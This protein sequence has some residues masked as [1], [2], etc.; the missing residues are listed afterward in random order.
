M[1][2][3]TFVRRCRSLG[4]AR[5][6]SGQAMLIVLAA[7]ALM[8]TVPLVVITT[9]VNQLP[10][11]TGNLNWNAAY[12][13]AQA[14]LNDYLQ[15]VDANPSYTQWSG[16]N[17]GCS[18]NPQTTPNV[19][20]AFC[21]WASSPTSTSP[22]A[23]NP[24]EWYEYSVIT[25]NGKVVLTV[26][27]KAGTG[28]RA[29]VRTFTYQMTPQA[30]LDDIYWTNYEEPS[31]CT[32][33]SCAIYFGSSDVLNGPVYSNDYFNISGSPTFNATVASSSANAPYWRCDY[34]NAWLL[35]CQGQPATASPIFNDGAPTYSP[36][37]NI[38][39]N[40]TGPD[41]NPAQTLGCYIAGPNNTSTGI[42]IT[43]SG[44]Q[45]TWTTTPG[46]PNQ[47]ATV[48]NLLANKNT[49][50]GA[51]GAS[52]TFS[53]LGSALFYVNGDIVIGSSQGAQQV[54][55]F[56]DL[57]STG[58]ITID[59]S[60]QYPSADITWNGGTCVALTGEGCDTQD[61]L[62][63]IAE[64]NVI[65]NDNNAAT[66]IDAAMVAIQGSFYN[67]AAT[68][69]C[70]GYGGPS[71]NPNNCPVL[72][73]FGSIAQ[74]TRGLVGYLDGNSHST[75]GYAKNYLYDSS[76]Q[77]LW[78]PFFIPPAGA[79]WTP[80]NYTELKPGTSNEAVAGT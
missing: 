6:Q 41:Q 28:S 22:L 31:G 64:N 9:A 73:V 40:A 52:V 29:V 50:C 46:Y 54:Q 55:G 2:S 67:A 5:D 57:V 71:N 13:A 61:A 48:Q 78:P 30:T 8:A 14:G 69:N 56:L 18:A 37:E 33:P 63:L 58:S 16:N 51:G 12:E 15:Q 23:T 3:A 7:L 24:S 43:L 44:N 1:L 60:V 53:S 35:G 70:P 79:T 25:T 19:N 75:Q 47:P 32:T 4:R 34:N 65:V 74:N 26:S 77:T 11:T 66:T 49:N 21:E 68:N 10:L 59:G 39:T 36:N 17:T 72:T 62:G 42:T 76:L 45:L 27:G 80:K 20:D 38:I